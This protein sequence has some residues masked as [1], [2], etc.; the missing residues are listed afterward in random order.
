MSTT[1]FKYFF[2][3]LKKPESAEFSGFFANLFFG[4]I[5]SNW[6]NRAL[7]PK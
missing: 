1:F 5:S 7:H 2:I 4:F 3:F 6:S